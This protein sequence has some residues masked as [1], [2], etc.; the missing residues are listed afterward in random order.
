MASKHL[1]FTWGGDIRVL[2]ALFLRKKNLEEG[3]PREA[4]GRKIGI[5]FNGG[6]Q[7][8][9]LMGG[10]ALALEEAGLTNVFDHAVGCST[11]ALCVWYFCAGDAKKGSPVYYTEG[12]KDNYI[13]QLRPWRMLDL[14]IVD[15]IIRKEEPINMDRFKAFPGEIHIGLTD[16]KTGKGIFVDP[17]NFKDSLAPVVTS[18]AIPLLDG[19]R[20]VELEGGEYVDGGIAWPM[21]I[22]Y[23]VESLHCTDLLVLMTHPFQ[24]AK[25]IFIDR[26]GNFLVSHFYSKEFAKVF[27]NRLHVYNEEIA[28]AAE[29]NHGDARIC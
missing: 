5:L 21:P 14:K 4:D 17:R 28:Y 9:V 27:R 13:R 22:D 7:R 6:G 1:T 11:G 29:G 19:R 10:I 25:E 2:D 15:R 18:C 12:V 16:Y 20:F 8:G 24:E 26:L 3:K 23:C